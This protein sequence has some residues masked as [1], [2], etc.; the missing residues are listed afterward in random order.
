MTYFNSNSFGLNNSEYFIDA[1]F[2]KDNKFDSTLHKVNGLASLDSIENAL[3]FQGLTTTLQGDFLVGTSNEDVYIQCM[4]AN[5]PLPDRL[6]PGGIE[7]YPNPPEP[8]AED[9][10]RHTKLQQRMQ[11]QVNN[12]TKVMAIIK[13]MVTADTWAIFRT[14]IDDPALP[15]HAKLYAMQQSIRDGF[16]QVKHSTQLQMQTK[17]TN[18]PAIHTQHQFQP[19]YNQMDRLQ[20]ALRQLQS[21][22]YTTD[23]EFND[24]LFTLLVGDLF[25]LAINAY[26]RCL[27]AGLNV[28]K[29]EFYNAIKDCFLSKSTIN[30]GFYDI[31]DSQHH[32]STL[33]VSNHISIHIPCICIIFISLCPSSAITNTIRHIPPT[34]HDPQ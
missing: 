20:S 24:K 33:F 19:V 13:N 3:A 10:K 12:Q 5:V 28:T 17:W 15:F 7:P 30:S 9:I 4:F 32:S 21:P 25:L 14:F 31:Q 27:K 18:L 1:K 8:T 11:S 2:D 23:R 34:I 16:D 29:L 6:W 26:Q 22:I